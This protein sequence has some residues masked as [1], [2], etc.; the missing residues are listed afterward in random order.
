[1]NINGFFTSY[2]EG[3]AVIETSATLDLDTMEI[4][5]ESVEVDNDA[6][7]ILTKEEFVSTGGEV[8]EVC[9]ECH[10]YVTRNIMLVNGDGKECPNCGVI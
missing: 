5:T 1:M 4:E 8:Y 10:Q 9:S 6:C 2:W 7:D 3:G